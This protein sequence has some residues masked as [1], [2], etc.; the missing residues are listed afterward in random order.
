MDGNGEAACY[1]NCVGSV[2]PYPANTQYMA[3]MV[4][5]AKQVELHLLKTPSSY[6]NYDSD[7]HHTLL[8]RQS[9]TDCL[10]DPSVKETFEINPSEPVA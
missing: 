8:A 7:W 1:W 9:S 2:R 10:M 3:A 5:H 4:R 6:I